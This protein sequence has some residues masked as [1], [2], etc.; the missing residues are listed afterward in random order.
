MV[1]K[2]LRGNAGENGNLAVEQVGKFGIA[3]LEFVNRKRN[4][5]AGMAFGVDVLST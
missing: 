2:F 5:L 3:A 1:M 4:K